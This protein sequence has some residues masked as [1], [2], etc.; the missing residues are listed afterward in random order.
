MQVEFASFGPMHEEIREELKAAM[1]RVMDESWFIRGKECTSFEREFAKYCG[2]QFAVG[3]GNGLDAL[4]LILCALGIGQ[5]DEVIVP[6]NTFIATALAV[7]HTGAIPVLV[8]PNKDTYTIDTEKIEGAITKHT[9]A[10]IPVHLYGRAA[11]ME[12]IQRMAKKYGLYVIEDA[13]QA[14]G[15]MYYGKKVG[16]FGI[17]AGFS[18]Y[19]G[20]NLGALGDGGC[21]TTNDPDLA[22]KVRILS[23]YGAAVRY[24]HLFLGTNSRLDELQAAFLRIKLKK[25]E[26][27]NRER[28]RIARMYLEE[29]RNPAIV[30]PKEDEEGYESVWHIFAVRCRQRNELEQW[31]SS[32]GIGTAKHYPIPIHRQEA[33]QVHY[34]GKSY[35]IAE[36][37]GNTELSL[38]LFYGMK[39]EEIRAVIHA[40]NTFQEH[41]R[42]GKG[43]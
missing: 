39:E 4:Y 24:H 36:E 26:K 12:P 15:A 1:E 17:A 19:P 41:D 16:S 7:S 33:Y 21:V 38:P 34:A 35:P 23:N 5:G 8:E 25:L 27:W 31:L 43:E 29:I 18:F 32:H 40:V 9:R 22:E 42:V 14:H 20:K 11:D 6:S 28:K 10:I 3:V 13:A 37:L 2:C 30:L